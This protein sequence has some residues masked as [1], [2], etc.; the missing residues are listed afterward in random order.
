MCP[1]FSDQPVNAA[2]LVA[3]KVGLKVDRPTK[4]GARSVEAY[5]SQV[6]MAIGTV[7]LDET[8]GVEATSLKREIASSGGEEEAERILLQ[9]IDELKQYH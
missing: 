6:G 4:S 8:F 3:L 7:I 9:A 5:R 1:T 2:K